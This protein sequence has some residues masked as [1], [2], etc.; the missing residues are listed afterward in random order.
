[1][2]IILYYVCIF[3]NVIQS[4]RII[5]NLYVNSCKNC[6]HHKPDTSYKYSSSYSSKE[7]LCRQFGERD[8]VTDVIKYKYAVST[9]NNETECGEAGLYFEKDEMVPYKK[10]LYLVLQ[11][12]EVILFSVLLT[13]LISLIK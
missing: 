5:K 6:I 2:I 4:E 12:N 11:Y 13:Y 7:S 1:M 9:R 8:I 3:S 10:L